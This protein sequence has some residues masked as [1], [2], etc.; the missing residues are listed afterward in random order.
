MEIIDE[1]ASSDGGKDDRARPPSQVTWAPRRVLVPLDGSLAAGTVL[2]FV[3][4]IARP[5]NLEI[6]LLRVVPRIAPRVLE[7]ARPVVIDPSERIAREAEEYLRT[8]AERVSANGVRVLTTV[9]VGDAAT[10]IV[11]GAGE[12]DV[13]LIAM[14]THGRSALARW[15]F[16]A[17]AEAVLR[18]AHIPVFVVRATGAAEARMAA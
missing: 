12:C 7:G 5:L 6:A 18:R 10:E 13:D 2:P 17:V 14:T 1:T 3:L 9:R 15:L 8:I 16:G 11:A 4:R